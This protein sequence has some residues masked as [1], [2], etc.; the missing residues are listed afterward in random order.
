[1]VLWDPFL[2]KN[3]LKSLL[4]GPINSARDLHKK[5]SPF[6]NANTNAFCIQTNTKSRTIE[7][8]KKKKK[9]L[10]KHKNVIGKIDFT[11][12]Y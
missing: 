6:T 12:Y 8:Q 5:S 11:H 10:F 9:K 7:E 4:A 2:K 3:L 1:M